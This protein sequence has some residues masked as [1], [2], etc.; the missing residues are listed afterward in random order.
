MLRTPAAAVVPLD[1][2]APRASLRA[3]HAAVL[4]AAGPVDFLLPVAGV[5]D[6]GRTFV[7]LHPADVGDEKRAQRRTPARGELTKQTSARRQ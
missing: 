7:S 6:A 5:K 2:K 3:A 4:A 1:I